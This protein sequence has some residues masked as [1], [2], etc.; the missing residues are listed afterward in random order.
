MAALN[1]T[2]ILQEI[3]NL[4]HLYPDIWDEGDEQLLHDMLQGSTEAFEFLSVVVDRMQDSA[5][6]A[7]GIA[8]RIAELELR[9]KRYVQR[10]KAMRNLALKV[11]NAAG[12]RKCELPEAT[13]SITKGTMKV[14]VPDDDAV[15]D[16]FCVFEKKVSKTKLKE[17]LEAGETL[18]YAVLE[19][20]P[21]TLSVRKK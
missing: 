12:Q 19:R 13:L 18:N 9:Q 17:A 20:G 11:M 8:T 4:K 7:G 5:S 16:R 6:M 14:I 10:E 1:P 21:E 3:A 2:A 15:P